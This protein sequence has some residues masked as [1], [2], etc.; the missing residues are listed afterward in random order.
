M[1]CQSFFWA[2]MKTKTVHPFK[3]FV[4]RKPGRSVIF[5]LKTPR[6]APCAT[7]RL[8][9]EKSE[10]TIREERPTSLILSSDHPGYVQGDQYRC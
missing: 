1:T 7:V 5:D 10:K 9:P 8:E 3:C 2:K 6:R 4:E